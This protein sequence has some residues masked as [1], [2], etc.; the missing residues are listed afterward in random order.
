MRRIDFSSEGEK[1]GLS[2]LRILLTRFHY[3]YF[4]HIIVGLWYVH[5]HLYKVKDRVPSENYLQST[6]VT[7]NF[8]FVVHNGVFQ[9]EMSQ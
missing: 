4:N 5:L 7:F 6:T 8:R 1:G 2:K 3:L 9:S